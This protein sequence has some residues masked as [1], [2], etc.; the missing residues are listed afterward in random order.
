MRAVIVVDRAFGRAEASLLSR[1]EIGLAD[2]GYRV[3]HAVPVATMSTEPSGIYSV[4][5]GYVDTG[6]P[7]TLRSRVAALVE[8]LKALAEK[9]GDRGP[10]N[11][12]HACGRGAWPVGQ[13]LA[14]QV[15]SAVVLEVERA[16]LIGTVAALSPSAAATKEAP[17]PL[18][19]VPDESLR[20]EVLRRAPRA[21]THLVRWGVHVPPARHPQTGAPAMV[22]LVERG[23]SRTAIAAL[24]ALASV[25]RD[26]PDL[27]LFLDIADGRT[28]TLWRA[29]RRLGLL[30]RL[31]MVPEL[32]GRRE[33]ALQMDAL[34]LPDA[35]GVSHSLVLDAMACGLSVL[36][37]P[38]SLVETLIDGTTA[39]LVVAPTKLEWERAI[40]ETVLNAERWSLLGASSREYVRANRSVSRHLSSVLEAYALAQR[41]HENDLAT[42]KAIA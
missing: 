42:R 14:R 11:V 21:R 15:G 5:V 3:V 30:E 22:M 39:R 8:T 38:D 31:S 20:A 34:L 26:S 36:A 25:A 6:L 24:E 7:L 37:S 33:P 32:E 10:V 23:D 19:C 9:Q 29:A 27:M 41:L 35:E 18:F 4:T 40:R 17:S 1:L 16:S 2:E 12:V 13:E 28:A